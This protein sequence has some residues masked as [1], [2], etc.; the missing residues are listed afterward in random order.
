M[1]GV[2]FTE[3]ERI[4][5]ANTAFLELIGAG[6]ER[7][8]QGLSWRALT[9]REHAARDD[10]ALAEVRQASVCKLYEKDFLQMDGTRIPALVGAAQLEEGRDG[11]VFFVLDDR[12][13]KKAEEL[14]RQLMGIVSHDLR[15][16]LSA[17]NMASALLLNADDLPERHYKTVAR[18]HSSSERMRLLIGDLLDY[19][20]AR[21][22]RG[23]P[24]NRRPCDLATICNVVL[25]ESEMIHHDRDIRYQ[26]GAD[27]RGSWDPGRLSQ[28]VQN[29]IG[30]AVA[31][32]PAGSLVRLG[33]ASGADGHVTL[34]VHN[35]GPPIPLEFMPHLFQP[36]RRARPKGPGQQGFGLGL[37]IVHEIVRAHGGT[38]SFR[39]AEGEGTTFTVRLPRS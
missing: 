1:I 39:S 23:L 30:N 20:Q 26:P 29:L 22:G 2:F 33:W 13:R 7:L 32:S 14:Q 24:L 38:V 10:R 5:E 25:Q 4:A 36:F 9:P 6:R 27:G 18:I 3:G 15:S 16:P 21:V 31:H 37:F 28:V 8:Q 19:Q 11:L 12:E 34:E 17:V 35:D